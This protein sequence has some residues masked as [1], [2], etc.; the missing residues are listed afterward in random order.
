MVLFVVSGTGRAR[1]IW[2]A[3]FLDKDRESCEYHHRHQERE[4]ARRATPFRKGGGHGMQEFEGTTYKLNKIMQKLPIGCALVKGLGR[5]RLVEG[6]KEFFHTIG[7]SVREMKE[8]PSDMRNALDHHIFYKE[9]L[10]KLRSEMEAALGGDDVRQCEVRIRR[11]SGEVRWVEMRIRFFCYEGDDPC[12]L[13]SSGDIHERKLVE[14]ELHFQT[15]R[16]KMMEEIN[17]E[18]PFEYDVISKTVLVSARSNVLLGNQYGK[19][20]IVPLDVAKRVLHPDDCEKIVGMLGSLPATET[21]GEI[22]YRVNIAREEEKTEYAWHRT[23]YKS[24]RGVNGRIVKVIG[25]TKDI[26]EEWVLQDKM[27][28]RLRQDDLTGLLNRAAIK[29]EVE[30]FLMSNPAGRHA[31]FLVDVDNFKSIND[32]LGH[33]VGD[34]IIVNIAKKIRSL[35][36]GSDAI[37]RIGGD[38]F[39]ILM[40]YTDLY[41]AKAKAQRICDAVRQTYHG[42]DGEEI[43]TSCSVGI[44]MCGLEK[45]SYASLFAKAD[46]AMFEAKKAGKDGYR[47]AEPQELQPEPEALTQ[48]RRGRKEEVEETQDLDFISEAFVLLSGGDD[49]DESLSLLMERIGK[50][51]D[52]GFVSILECDKKK[53]ELVLTNSWSAE[54]G[55]NSTHRMIG[56]QDEWDVFESGLDDRGLAFVNDCYDGE[57]VSEAD[58]AVFHARHMRAFIKCKFSY[59]ELGEGYVC[60]CDTEKP[61]IWV[62]YEKETF[63]ELTRMLSVFVALR[64]QREEDQRAIRNL[65]K[66]DMLTGLYLEDA[67]KAIVKERLK[68]FDEDSAY[69]VIYA[70][71]NDFSYINENFGHSAG[72]ELLR[73]FARLAQRGEGSVS[74]RLY[75]DLFITFV[76]DKD[77]DTILKSI[78]DNCVEFCRQQKEIFVTCSIRLK[79]GVCFI[80]GKQE[81]LENA[82]ENANLARKSIKS[83]HGSFCRVYEDSMRREREMEKRILADFPDSLRSGRFKVYVQPKFRLSEFT[84]YGGE[85]LVRWQMPDGGVGQ[86]GAFIPVL[87]KS[88]YVVELDFY[89]FEEVLRYMRKWKKEGKELPVISVNF[90]R[91]H[92]EQNGIYNRISRLTEEYQVDPGCIEIEITESLFVTEY[93]LVKEEVYQLREDGFRVAIDDFGSGYS[94]LGMLLDIPADIVK[95]DKSFLDRE[96]IMNDR[97]F[98]TGMCRMIHSVGEEAIFEGIETQEQRQFLLSCGYQYG[99]GYLFDRP[100]PIADFQEKYMK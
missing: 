13:L 8:I 99:Q 28:R 5:W 55:I 20:C 41:Q 79:V 45:E 73:S 98:I 34:G 35:F 27:A 29:A 84:F 69:A 94:S 65:K 52:L 56:K 97:E 82:I 88:G 92:F 46:Q 23:S 22:E 24:I 66:C 32:K 70:D 10:D 26:T 19:D 81:S 57:N 48:D 4:A 43:V 95:L 39:M 37:G 91:S 17:K 86:P 12:F 47:A 54:G 25:R 16:Y 78:V 63:L 67:F 44:A 60:F 15:E 31:L 76:Q 14:Q 11:K 58:R 83:G 72:N 30:S 85:A 96:N 100:L 75:S 68:D 49:I 71:I 51:Y 74:C 53:K 77:R 50:Q 87:E 36:R 90:S 18:Y 3:N 64:A 21:Q 6:N 33:L 89:V 61:R 80:E 59:S 9:D 40:K 62:D 7:Y 93:D 38:E 2:P 1:A 42:K